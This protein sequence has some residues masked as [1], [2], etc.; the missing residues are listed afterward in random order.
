[1]SKKMDGIIEITREWFIQNRR[2]T[3]REYYEG[4][5]CYFAEI[6]LDGTN[7]CAG[8]YECLL[9]A[10]ESLIELLEED[11]YIVTDYTPPAPI[12]FNPVNNP[13]HYTQGGIECIDAIQA[14]LTPEEFRGFCK[15]NALKYIWRAE[16][17]GK[18]KEDLNKAT[19]YLNRLMEGTE[20]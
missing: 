8:S 12:P 5:T 16:H 20:E 10:D 14:A 17:K 2:L 3:R 7:Y 18:P 1:M 15:G 4:R 11:G 9:D 6:N 13:E 19:W